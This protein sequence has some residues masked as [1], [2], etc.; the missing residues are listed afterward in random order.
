[1]SKFLGID[2]SG[3]A[4][5]WR[6][7]LRN[8]TV[9]IATVCGGKPRLTELT[10]VQALPGTGSTFD[11]L[12]ELLRKGDFEVAAID[13]PFSIPSEHA[14]CLHSDLIQRVRT[15]PNGSD[16]PFPMGKSILELANA[17]LL[18]RQQKPLRE[19]EAFWVSRGIATRSTLWNGPRGGAPFTAACLRLIERAGRPCWPW[20][21]YQPGI[22]AEA[23][24]AAQLYQWN[25]PYRSYS[26][27]EG[28]GVRE[29]IVAGL[30]DRL[31]ID[32]DKAELMVA[33]PDA[34]DAVVATFAAMAVAR[35]AVVGFSAGPEDGFIAVAA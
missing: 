2:F 24:P 20:S 14:R 21:E 18:L 29:R 13:A 25:L 17:E 28:K 7:S 3:G 31:H 10:P 23:F 11:R 12:V 8:P 9:W 19:T 5:P 16:R 15:M 4:R 32:S 34:L 22:L 35:K 33:S 26:G 6:L 30:E 27:Q 1:M